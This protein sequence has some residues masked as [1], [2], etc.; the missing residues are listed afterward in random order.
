LSQ[1]QVLASHE[2]LMLRLRED[3]KVAVINNGNP[4]KADYK[5]GGATT[6]LGDLVRTARDEGSTM[7]HPEVFAGLRADVT[8]L[9]RS[10]PGIHPFLRKSMR[11]LA[12]RLP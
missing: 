8:G 12:S 6:A 10:M 7:S 11:R 5:N 4:Y 3:W 9:A 1:P 2:L